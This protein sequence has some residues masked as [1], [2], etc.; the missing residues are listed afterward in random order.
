MWVQYGDSVRCLYPRSSKKP[1]ESLDA[2]V[3]PTDAGV[4][5][6]RGASCGL[7]RY[8]FLEEQLPV[9]HSDL[10]KHIV[11]GFLID[12]MCPD[13]MD[14]DFTFDLLIHIDDAVLVKWRCHDCRD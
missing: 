6:N 4:W 1:S 11:D 14:E 7:D 10:V 13:D 3:A 8:N 9:F 2:G 12:W 5:V